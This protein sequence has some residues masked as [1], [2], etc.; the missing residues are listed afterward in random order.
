MLNIIIPS[1]FKLSSIQD[2]SLSISFLSR[3]QFDFFDH[4]SNSV[5]SKSLVEPG[6][7]YCRG[8]LSTI[9]LLVLTSLIQL[10]FL[11]KMSLK[12]FI[13]QPNLTRSP[14][15]LRLSL[16]LMFPH[17]DGEG[18]VPLTSLYLIG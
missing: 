6:N 5:Q 8:R 12:V 15:V 17:T 13:I 9:D 1:V 18:F 3:D 10:L 7:S 2:K 16:Q 4:L 14:T 11:L